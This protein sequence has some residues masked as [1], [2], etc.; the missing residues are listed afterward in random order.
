M[1]T[2]ALIAIIIVLVVII[3][4]VYIKNSEKKYI[5]VISVNNTMYLLGSQSIQKMKNDKIIKS[6]DYKFEIKSGKLIKDQILLVTKDSLI[7]VCPKTLKIL[8]KEDLPVK[9]ILW[10]DISVIDLGEGIVEE[11]FF[12]F[13]QSGHLLCF[14][15]GEDGWTLEGDWKVKNKNFSGGFVYGGGS[16]GENN[17]LILKNKDYIYFYN[18]NLYLDELEQFKKIKCTDIIFENDR[19]IKSYNGKINK[20]FNLRNL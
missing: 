19:Y 6:K 2:Y 18:I 10:V 8:E 5:D 4:I 20:I 13:T 12:I 15:T 9:N 3:Y 1:I 14:S 17:T 11:K 7:W 16:E